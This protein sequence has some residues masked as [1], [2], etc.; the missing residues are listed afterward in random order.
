MTKFTKPYQYLLLLL[1]FL[2]AI[3]ILLSSFFSIAQDQVSKN[4]FIKARRFY[5]QKEI[6][7]D[8]SL[9]PA[10]MAADRFRLAMAD[11]E[12][13]LYLQTAYAN[14]RLFYAHRLLEKGQ[15]ELSLTTLTKAEKYLNQALREAKVLESELEHDQAYAELIFF[16][17][18]S[19]TK[20]LRHLENCRSGFSAEQQ[21]VLLDLMSQT[22]VLADELDLNY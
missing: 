14:R 21:S 7:P 19:V 18:E 2:L 20:H 3:S 5:V 16:L 9:Y 15:L 12:R 6:L 11:R 1:A 8:H 10:L 22:V 13:R 4:A 17:T